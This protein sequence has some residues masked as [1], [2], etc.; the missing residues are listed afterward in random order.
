[1]KYYY[2]PI[3][4]D[5]S[6]GAYSPGQLDDDGKLV[7]AGLPVPCD[8]PLCDQGD[9]QRFVVGVYL[10]TF[11]APSGW[12][13]KTK[14]EVSTDYPDQVPWVLQV[15]GSASTVDIYVKPSGS[16][17]DAGPQFAARL[18]QN[19]GIAVP[20]AWAPGTVVLIKYEV[21]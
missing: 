5:T 3:Y 20:E 2:T 15:K 11:E 7:E 9:A 6:T 14:E 10:D 17:A 19:A 4:H 1:M 8:S 12:E 18:D 21:V 16:D 13:E